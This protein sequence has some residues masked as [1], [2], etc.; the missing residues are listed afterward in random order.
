MGRPPPQD[1]VEKEQWGGVSTTASSGPGSTPPW[2]AHRGPPRTTGDHWG[3]RGGGNSTAVPAQRTG[4]GLPF[5]R[6]EGSA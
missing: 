4:P 1:P 2:E 6:E 5:L 3:H